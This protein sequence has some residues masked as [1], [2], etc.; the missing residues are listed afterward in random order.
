M[1]RRD[2]I[3]LAVLALIVVLAVTLANRIDRA[4]AGA[5]T[6]LVREAVRNAAVTC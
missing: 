1:N 5:E 3:K 2:I 4:Q 6:N